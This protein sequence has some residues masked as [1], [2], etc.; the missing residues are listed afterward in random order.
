MADRP[1][2]FAADRT[3]SFATRCK[4]CQRADRRRLSSDYFESYFP[5][6]NIGFQTSNWR[7]TG[8][9][10]VANYTYA[11]AIDDISSTFSGNNNDFNLGFSPFVFE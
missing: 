3:G 5:T 7:T 1:G 10:L 6:L 2:H 8:L 11:H 9:S 4:F